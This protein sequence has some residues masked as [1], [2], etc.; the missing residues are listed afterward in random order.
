MINT[1]P[2]STP[3]QV[4]CTRHSLQP[5]RDTINMSHR[6]N[7]RLETSHTTLA[8]RQSMVRQHRESPP[9]PALYLTA[10]STQTVHTGLYTTHPT[11]LCSHHYTHDTSLHKQK[12][13]QDR[14]L[15]PRITPSSSHSCSRL[16]LRQ[17]S[18][19]HTDAQHRDYAHLLAE[20]G[21]VVPPTSRKFTR[22]SRTIREVPSTHTRNE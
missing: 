1:S 3:L 12:A 19:V 21:I 14:P 7:E 22:V 13:H 11:T 15:P 4:Q 18:Y 6:T 2:S 17:R 5:S 9:Y 20:V 16:Q 10:R 8:P